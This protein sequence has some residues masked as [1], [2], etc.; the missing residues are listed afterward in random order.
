MA[1]RVPHELEFGD[2]RRVRAYFQRVIRQRSVRATGT[3]IREFHRRAV[4][5]SI[6]RDLRESGREGLA[7][8]RELE[9][10]YTGEMDEALI[11]EYR[12]VL[13]G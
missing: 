6:V 9:R 4:A 8:V 1:G 10:S 11:D 5:E 12:Q 2:Q 3:G 13:C 7:I